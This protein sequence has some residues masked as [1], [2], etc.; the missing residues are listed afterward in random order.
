[1]SDWVIA[2]HPKVLDRGDVHVWLADLDQ[3]EIVVEQ[4][5]QTLSP[6]EQL[7][8]ERFHFARDR[9]RYI[10]A[11]GM[12]RAIL[13]DY[14]NTMPQQVRFITGE[15]GKPALA[16]DQGQL[17]FNLSHSEGLALLACAYGRELGVDIEY[18]RPL[19]DIDLIAAHFFAPAERAVLSQVAPEQKLQAFYACWTRK[20][21][22]IKAIGMGLTMPL[23][24][25]VVSLAPHEDA[26]LLWVKDQPQ[27]PDRWQLRALTPPTD[28]AATLLVAGAGWNFSCYRW[29]PKLS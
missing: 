19:D 29:Q 7:H 3:P 11:H 21:A 9:R 26:H 15:Y 5:A 22:Y 8:A 24:H 20:E 13:A 4:M 28:Y 27:E 16:P 12:M 1:M 2:P 18:M 23:D 10:T 14:L 25:F 6:E 17:S